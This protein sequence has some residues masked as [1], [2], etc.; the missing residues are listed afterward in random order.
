M[1]EMLV[2]QV[3]AYW[4][5]PW[6]LPLLGALERVLALTV[7]IGLSLLVVRSLAV[8]NLGWLALAVAAHTVVDGVAMVLIQWEWTPLAL[9]GVMLVFALGA[10]A[11]I[12]ALRRR[13]AEEEPPVTAATGHKAAS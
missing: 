9:E 6:T 1:A 2:A 13:E 5:T 4:S 10:L 3:D 8:R 11:L 12:L 7:Q